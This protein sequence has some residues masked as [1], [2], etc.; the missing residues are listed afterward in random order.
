MRKQIER[1]KEIIRQ[2]EAK[3]I[4]YSR[5]TP[6]YAF[7]MHKLHQQKQEIEGILLKMGQKGMGVQASSLRQCMERDQWEECYAILDQLAA[8]VPEQHQATG[9]PA[10]IREEVLADFGEADRCFQHACYRSAMILCGRVLEIALHRKY[11][12][13]TKQD[14]LETQPGIGLGKLIA[15]LKE[16]QVAFDPGVTEQ[17]HLLNAMRV[18][19]VHK[20]QELFLPSKGQAEAAILYTKDI[21]EKLFRRR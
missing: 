7:G 14:I 4:V 13:V 17:I 5:I 19:S 3:G 15:K 8:Q 2:W 10:D 12:E 16:K 11:Y 9:I 18:F 6:S 21:V 20:K 1:I